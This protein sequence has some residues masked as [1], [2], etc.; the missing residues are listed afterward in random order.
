[1][2]N[3]RVTETL[4]LK[5]CLRGSHRISPCRYA[6]ALEAEKESV[7]HPSWSV[8]QVLLQSPRCGP[9]NSGQ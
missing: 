3:P 5:V 7:M 4:T 9:T 1:M 8:W 2:L 6:S